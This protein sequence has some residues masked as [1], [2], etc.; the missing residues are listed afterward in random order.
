M[1][2]KTFVSRGKGGEANDDDV[3]MSESLFL[4][5]DLRQEV[6]VLAR[7]SHP[8]VVALLGVSVRPMCIALEFAPLGNLLGVLEARVEEL[9]KAQGDLSLQ[10]VLRMP[11]GVLG[12]IMSTKVAAQVYEEDTCGPSF[13]LHMFTACFFFLFFACVS[14]RLHGPW[15]TFTTLVSSTE[16]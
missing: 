14:H 9:K 16:T 1:A 4:F 3:Y 5:R 15:S 6:T 7:L 11:G 10:T 12:H 2:V 8:Y 13:S